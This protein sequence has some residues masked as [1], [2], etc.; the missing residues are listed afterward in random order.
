[1]SLLAQQPDLEHMTLALIWN[2]MW[3]SLR[4]S[5]QTS[6]KSDHGTGARA[7]AASAP[8][9]TKQTCSVL[10]PRARARP[11]PNQVEYVTPTD[12]SSDGL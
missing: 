1:M 7:R 3:L 2:N 4:H 10:P 11:R 9:S 6:A 12:T 5:V 8:H